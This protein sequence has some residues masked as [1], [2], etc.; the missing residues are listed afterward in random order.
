MIL[1]DWQIMQELSDAIQPF[2]VQQ[3]NPASYDVTVGNSVKL[4]ASHGF[5]D[6]PFNN[7]GYVVVNPGECVLVSTTE[8]IALPNRVAAEFILKSSIAR[9]FFQHMNAGWC[10]PG[11]HGHLT[12]EYVNLSPR[13]FMLHKNMRIGQMV[14]HKLEAPNKPY[15]GKYNGQIEATIPLGEIYHRQP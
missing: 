14:F 11:W 8:L 5:V 2:T 12:M 10:D 7:E 4:C 15:N 3:L 9:H 1:C 13:H 6:L